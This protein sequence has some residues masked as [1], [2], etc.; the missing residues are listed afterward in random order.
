[1]K[2]YRIYSFQK[3][4]KEYKNIKCKGNL[5]IIDEVHELRNMNLGSEKTGLR[6]KAALHCTFQAKKILLM[7]ATPFVNS[8]TD[9]ISLT[10]L[11]HGTAV[12]TKKSQIKEVNDFILYLR[13][14]VDYVKPIFDSNF[15]KVREHIVKIKMEPSYEKDYCELIKGQIVNDSVFSSPNAFY[16]AHRRAVNKIGAGKEYFSMKMKMAIELIGLDKAMIYSNWLNFGLDPI[17]DAL[18]EADISSEGYSGKISKKVKDQIIEDFNDYEFQVLVTAP[19]G[20]LGLDLVGVRKVIVMDPVWHPSGMRQI[21]GRAARY[22]SH[23]HLT[24]KDRVVD[25]YYMILETSD[26]SQ[27]MG[28]FSGDSIVYQVIEKKKELEKQVIGMLEKVN[29]K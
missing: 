15:P 16:N 12:I 17:S 3:V 19:A 14:M 26:E 7:T 4:Q 27:K 10:N 23:S 1:M 2:K 18:E 13:G 28:C 21:K 24:K 25:V 29:I 5:V 20:K 9:L 6:A 11:V 8:M 22:G